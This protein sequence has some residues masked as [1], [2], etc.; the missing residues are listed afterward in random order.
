MMKIEATIG[1][2][3]MKTDMTSVPSTMLSSMVVTFTTAHSESPRE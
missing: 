3:V 2:G 1:P